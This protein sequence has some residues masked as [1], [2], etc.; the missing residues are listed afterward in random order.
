MTDTL[1]DRI[2]IIQQAHVFCITECSCGHK[3]PWEKSTEW[4]ERAEWEWARHV[5]DA[6][7]AIPGVAV[8]EIPEPDKGRDDAWIDSRVT[9]YS[10]D[11]PSV[12]LSPTKYDAFILPTDRARDLAAALLA[13]A[14]YLERDQAVTPNS[15]P[16]SS[17]LN[18]GA[19]L[20]AERDQ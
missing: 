13:A 9:V 3:F 5:A 16:D 7:L 19:H 18:W 6:I 11:A 20:I 1:R 15:C 14:D 17:L 12:R 2:A 4:R 8:V 10:T